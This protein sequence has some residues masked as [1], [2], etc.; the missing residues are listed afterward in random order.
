ME[1]PNLRIVS[2]RKVSLRASDNDVQVRLSVELDARTLSSDPGYLVYRLA[3][4]YKLG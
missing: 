3:T 2:N 4:R 1:A